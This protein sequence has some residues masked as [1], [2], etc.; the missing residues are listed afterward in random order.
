MLIYKEYKMKT[1]MSLSMALVVVSGCTSANM[2]EAKNELQPIT[3]SAIEDLFE[4]KENSSGIA[5]TGF[6]ED[7]LSEKV[8][9]PSE[10]NG[11]A[12]TELTP[13]VVFK[14]KTINHA[15]LP[16][17]ITTIG[18]LNFTSCPKLETINVASDNPNYTSQDGILFSKD[19]RQLLQVPALFTG[20]YEIPTC[21]QE[22]G[23]S[24][25]KGCNITSLTIPATTTTVGSDT[26]LE[27]SKLTHFIVAETNPAFTT[28]DGIL[29]SKDKTRL[30]K[31]PETRG[32]EYSVPEGVEVLEKG[33]FSKNIYLTRVNMPNT[34]K[35]I[36][37][38][39]FLECTNLTEATLPESLETLKRLSFSSTKITKFH[40]SKNVAEFDAIAFRHCS[41][42]T[43]ISIDKEN[44][45]FT[46][47]DQVLYSKDMTKLWFC[48]NS[49]Q[50]VLEVPDSVTTIGICPFDC[51]KL[52]AIHLPITLEKFEFGAGP[53][54]GTSGLESA[55]IP[56]KIDNLGYFSFIDCT[57]LKWV[58]FLGDAPELHKSALKGRPSNLKIYYKES[59]TGFD[60]SLWDGMEI[61]ACS[62]KKVQ[63][64]IQQNRNI[65]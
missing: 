46:I 3:P 15:V 40:L 57:N 6:N 23:L 33:A 59:A 44:P 34:L 20:A 22:L 12:V 7:K 48:L 56:P 28:I 39:V 1:W 58:L 47:V 60:S 62:E 13:R 54:F 61:E 32:G 9:F 10:I 42:L 51:D 43:E 35:T 27:L 50:G 38:D 25:F 45:N 14:N 31:F 2:L 18:K 53:F 49:K 29:F 37:A 64:L 55:V 26:F 5:I 24:A 52:S 41:D 17:S 63:E 11:K 8:I 65:K 30:I 4:Y 21:V 19:R 36:E 16:S